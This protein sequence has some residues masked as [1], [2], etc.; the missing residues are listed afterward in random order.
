MSSELKDGCFVRERCLSFRAMSTSCNESSTQFKTQLH[1][2]LQTM[3][4][5]HA[6]T[7]TCCQSDSSKDV[8]R[9][10]FSIPKRLNKFRNVIPTLEI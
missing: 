10:L 5:Q 7:A 9:K 4:A 6:I 1:C 3:L 2:S 8:G